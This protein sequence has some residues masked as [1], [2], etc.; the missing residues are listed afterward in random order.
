MKYEKPKIMDLGAVPMNVDGQGVD[1]CLPGGGAG[2]PGEDCLNGGGANLGTCGEGTSPSMPFSY[3]KP[4]AGDE[5]ACYSGIVA[6][7]VSNSGTILENLRYGNQDAT[8]AQV[9]LACRTAGIYDFITGL[10][11]GFETQVGEKGV[12][13]S[14]GQKQRLAIARALIKD[15]DILILDE[16]TSALDSIVER[17]I[18]DLLPAMV[19]NKT[20]FVVAHRLS[21]IQNS[22]R[23]LVLNESHL[24]AVGSHHA[25]LENNPFYRS[26]VSNQQIIAA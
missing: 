24:V 7:F 11:E 15:P 6:G 22:D 10:P 8:Q 16:P 19:R 21:T 18:F 1:V 13:L 2:N 17:S 5:Y 23:I 4:G 3:C 9:D 12:R 20:L 26:L 14:E 25:L